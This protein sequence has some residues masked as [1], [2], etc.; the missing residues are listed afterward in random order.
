MSDI[1]E[2]MAN[3]VDAYDALGINIEDINR[4]AHIPIRELRPVPQIPE[5]YAN[6]PINIVN[7][8]MR[9]YKQSAV[10]LE[11]G[12]KAYNKAKISAMAARRTLLSTTITTTGSQSSSPTDIHNAVNIYAINGHIYLLCE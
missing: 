10:E 2:Q 1:I 8:I 9:G 3:A 7:D 5:Q 4:T 11:H 6:L 12:R